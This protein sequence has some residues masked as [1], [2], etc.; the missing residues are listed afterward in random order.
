MAKP[1]LTEQGYQNEAVSWWGAQLNPADIPELMWP[2]SNAVYDKMRRTDDQVL[3]VLKAVTYPIMS[4][5][6]RIDGTGCRDEVTQLIASDLGLPVLGA[7]SDAPAR[8]GTKFNFIEHLRLALLKLPFGHSYFEQ[9]YAYDDVE[10]LY[11]LKKLAW[12][13]HRTITAI[14]VAADGGLIAITQYGVPGQVET[15]IPVAN[16]VAYVNDRE[17]GN[18]LGQSL[19]RPA[20]KFWLLKEMTL[21][22]QAQTNERNGLGINI[23]TAAPPPDDTEDDEELKREQEEREE[24]LAMARALRAGTTTGASLRNGATMTTQGVK[25]TLPDPEKA[26]NRYDDGI[27]RSVLAHFLTLGGND[28]TGSYALG[29][30]FA[31]FFTGS[32]QAVAKEIQATLQQHVIEDL[33]DANWGPDEPAPQLVFDQIGSKANIDAPGIMSLA[34]SGMLTLDAPLEEWIRNRFGM[35]PTDP[36]TSRPNPTQ[37]TGNTD[38]VDPDEDDDTDPPEGD[39]PDPNADPDEG[40]EK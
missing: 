13:P 39:K 40:D 25:G 19:L 24:G 34:Q 10:K 38:P 12:R 4:T 7:K 31:E 14:E 18:W 27:A 37:K 28:A 6:W 33:V 30:T 26:L 11:H 2:Q 20:Y 36:S 29:D 17:G 16:L 35:P 8:T 9:V 23:Y 5:P 21:R 22:V 15:T 1:N 32:L 3:S